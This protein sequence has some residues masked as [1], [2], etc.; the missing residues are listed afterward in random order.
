MHTAA[1]HVAR[2]KTTLRVQ[3]SPSRRLRPLG[4]LAALCGVGVAWVVWWDEG[5]FAA[6]GG[7]DP[8][9]LGFQVVVELAERVEF[10]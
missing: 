2:G 6:A 8:A 3:C 4:F 10:V 5:T 9:V 1:V 7:E